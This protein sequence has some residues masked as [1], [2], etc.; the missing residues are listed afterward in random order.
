MDRR[1]EQR[2]HL[3]GERGRRGRATRRRKGH[4]HRGHGQLARLPVELRPGPEAR[5][6]AGR[7]PDEAERR[8]GGH[9][10]T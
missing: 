7:R 2:P 4:Q 10:P 3:G 9:D 5:Q 1:L 8:T 6:Q